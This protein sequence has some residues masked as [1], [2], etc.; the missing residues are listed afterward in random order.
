VDDIIDSVAGQGDGK[1]V[2]GGVSA[3]DFAAARYNQNGSLDT[4]FD[5]DGKVKYDLASGSSD[6]ARFVGVQGDSKIVLAGWSSSA[7]QTVAVMRLNAN[8]SADTSFSGD[9][10]V[11]SDLEVGASDAANV[12]ALQTDGKITVAG[13]SGTDFLLARYNTDGSLD[14][15]LAGDGSQTTNFGGVEAAY[16]LAVQPD[17]RIVVGGIS[18]G[19]FALARYG[20]L[21]V[22]LGSPTNLTVNALESN[23][24]QLTWTDNSDHEF[25]FRIE[26][27]TGSGGTWAQISSPTT[28]Q[29][30]YTD[31]T[32]VGGLQCYYRVRARDVS[33]MSAYS[34]QANDTTPPATPTALTLTGS[35]SG[36]LL[37]WA[38]NTESSLAG[39][40][41]YRS[42]AAD[43]TYT[44][45]NTSGLLTSSTYNHTAATAGSNGY[46]IVTA[47][48]GAG[49]ESPVSIT[50][51][52]GNGAGSSYRPPTH[53]LIVGSGGPSIHVLPPQGSTVY[54]WNY[55]NESSAYGVSTSWSPGMNHQTYGTQTFT[56]TLSNLPIHSGLRISANASFEDF[57]NP[58]N[59]DLFQ[60]TADGQSWSQETHAQSWPNGG[61]DDPLISQTIVHT[62]QQATITITGSGFEGS[63][64]WWTPEI[65]QVE[66]I[67]PPTVDIAVLQHGSEA[68]DPAAP[69]PPGEGPMPVKFRVTRTG[70]YTGN[71]NSLLVF[72]DR[73]P[74][75]TATPDVDYEYA[76][77]PSSVT[78]LAS[79]WSVDFTV[80]VKED[81]GEIEPTE[82]IIAHLKL[83]DNPA[84]RVYEFAT[85]D[86]EAKAEVADPDVY[87]VM[88]SGHTQNGGHDVDPENGPPT[89]AE[90]AATDSGIY[91]LAKDI[92]EAKYEVVT[93]SED[94]GNDKDTPWPDVGDP[95]HCGANKQTIADHIKDKIAQAK[96]RQRVLQVALIGYS[97]GGGTAYWVAD[98]LSKPANNPDISF[99]N[100]KFTGY[101]DAV[102]IPLK[103]EEDRFPPGSD[104]HVNFCQTETDGKEW[105]PEGK[106]TAGDGPIYCNVDLDQLDGDPED[107]EFVHFGPNGIDKDPDVHK[108]MIWHLK[109]GTG[110][111]NGQVACPY[112]DEPHDDSH[113]ELP[114]PQ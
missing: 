15:S 68:P 114:E 16:G 47:A 49:N 8:G 24:V 39:Y 53:S 14:T 43:G 3:N 62:A 51:G 100:L 36:I 6:R 19:D 21:A 7:S 103:N 31:Y 97:H 10:K 77:F 45:L 50:A 111:R 63:Q 48:D 28:D 73:P 81:E 101:I 107:S 98:Y 113:A 42:T 94:P 58:P 20:H 35:S 89:A 1:I 9:G 2:V 112:E 23:Q 71:A 108:A 72:L 61:F 82:T 5:T 110:R 104:Y 64:D 26:R 57:F 11:L 84:N 79:Q 17:G 34:N 56:L 46:Y 30:S 65:V 80:D 91:K 85:G 32:T 106:K 109:N 37:D 29:T 83:A 74:G 52:E 99:Y 70:G 54:V 66:L 38:N 12:A 69:N 92:R 33:F 4:T 40:N 76:D 75:G 67:A 59:W 41:V 96:K 22:T 88:I 78:I 18:A 55:A 87:V 60:V 93:F 13:T 90:H 27:K 25:G 44:K 105:E 102:R 95:F 86:P